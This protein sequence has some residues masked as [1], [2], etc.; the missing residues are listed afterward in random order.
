MQNVFNFSR[1]KINGIVVWNGDDKID[2]RKIDNKWR[3]EAP[4]KDQAD[5]A[6]IDSLLSSDLE[7]YKRHHF[8]EG[9]RG[10]QK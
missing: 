6:L 9:D 10:R 2:L 8:R 4:I 7:M 5:S 3:L 1:D